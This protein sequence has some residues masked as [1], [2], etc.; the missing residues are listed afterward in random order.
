MLKIPSDAGSKKEMNE[1]ISAF[2]ILYTSH[3]VTDKIYLFT[4]RECVPFV[5]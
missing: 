4:H 5:V 1:G 3:I 2:N